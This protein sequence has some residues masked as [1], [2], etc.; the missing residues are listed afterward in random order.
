MM[1]YK[2]YS[3][4]DD[5]DFFEKYNQKRNKGDSPNE[6]IEKPIFDELL[7]DINEKKILDLGC[8]DG[9]MGAQLLNRG[10]KFY[11]GVEGSYKM[12]SLA[13]EVITHTNSRIQTC[14]IENFDF[15]RNEYEV[16]ISRLVFHLLEN[17]ELLFESIRNCFK[18]NGLFIFSVEHP[19]IT[20]N[21]ESYHKQNKR[22]NWIVDNYFNTG[23]RT[24]IWIGKKVIKYHRTLE[25]YWNLIKD[26]NFLIEDFKEAKPVKMYFESELEYQRR[27]RIP[28]F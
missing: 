5:E 13:R 12:A 15:P 25:D 19:I 27:N 18:E 28:L 1:K 11:H 4:Y 24:N 17:L 6:L 21:Y 14:D 8:G 22:K 2:S 9:K 23:E 20:S 16:V 3:V 7:G 26:S 10:A